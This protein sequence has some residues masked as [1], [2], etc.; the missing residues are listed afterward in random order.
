MMLSAPAA[1]EVGE[2][3]RVGWA[4]E[5]KMGEEGHFLVFKGLEPVF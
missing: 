3:G 1:E 4:A 2:G 5:K